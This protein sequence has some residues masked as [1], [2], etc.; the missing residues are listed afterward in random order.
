ML[1][2]KV[3]F[4]LPAFRMMLFSMVLY[5]SLFHRSLLVFEF[6]RTFLTFN[7][8]TIVLVLLHS[9]GVRALFSIGVL[10]SS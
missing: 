9:F 5:F 1:T 10:M 2:H 4:H 3:I 6:D 7:A 8:I